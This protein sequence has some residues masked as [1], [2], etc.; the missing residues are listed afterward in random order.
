VKRPTGRLATALLLLGAVVAAPVAS[1]GVASARPEQAPGLLK[2]LTDSTAGGATV[3]PAD[4]SAERISFFGTAP[5]RPA[6]R[7]AGVSAATAPDLAAREFVKGYGGLFGVRDAARELRLMKAPKTGD[8]GVRTVRFQQH[9]G[10]VPVI[11]GDV[12]VQLEAD[13]DVVAAYGETTTAPAALTPAITAEA[14]RSSAVALIARNREVAPATLSAGT[15][16]LAVYDSRILGVPGLDRPTLVWQTEVTASGAD[17]INEKVFV[18]A[19]RG[20][21]A[22]HFDQI[23][24]AEPVRRVCDNA[25]ARKTTDACTTA[26]HSPGAYPLGHDVRNAYDFS[27]RAVAFYRALGRHGLDG[28]GGTISSV[29]RY[30]E[31]IPAGGT[32]ADH[33]CPFRN[34][35]WN[36]KHVVYGDN[37]ANADDVVGH[38]LT[39]GVTDHESGLF[40][41]YQSG[42]INES[43]SDVFGELLD[44][45]YADPG[46]AR[47][48][49]WLIGEDNPGGAIRSMSDP[50]TYRHP[51]RMTSSYWSDYLPWKEWTP[52]SPTTWDAGGVHTNSGVNN[53]A[54]YLISNGGTFNGRTVAPLGRAKTARLYYTAALALTSAASYRDLYNVLL[55]SCNSLVGG[56]DGVTAADCTQVKN[57]LLAVEMST[58][59]RTRGRGP[60]FAPACENRSRPAMKFYDDMENHSSGNWVKT[61]V[62]DANHDGVWRTNP[63]S[64]TTGYAGQ[65]FNPQSDQLWKSTGWDP[66]WATSGTTNMWG[67]NG[68]NIVV[69]DIARTAGLIATG[70]TFLQFNHAYELEYGLVPGSTSPKYFDGGRVEFSVDGARTWAAVPTSWFTHNPYNATIYKEPDARY[71]RWDS[72]LAGARAFG[73]SSKG[74]TTSRISLKALASKPVRFRFRLATDSGGAGYGWFIDDVAVYNC[75]PYS[76]RLSVAVSPSTV[77]HGSATRV[78]GRLTYAGSLGGIAGKAVVIH[79]RR[80]TTPAPR[81]T[82][83]ATVTTDAAGAYRYLAK[84]TVNF[85]YTT[86]FVGAAP[87]LAAPVNEA[88][89][90]YVAPKLTAALNDTTVHRTTTAYLAGVVTPAHGG[91]RVYLQKKVSGSWRNITYLVLPASG[92][93]RLRVRPGVAGTHYYRAAIAAHADHAAGASPTATLRVS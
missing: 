70:G 39:H 32:A 9:F 1:T 7:P 15:P 57:A 3:V 66:T 34:A 54:A 44:L 81:W 63:Y 12:V 69:S 14:A 73:G 2:R 60:T 18:D 25:N 86:R 21:V 53:K 83:L 37:R 22:L 77:V 52:A 24:H 29:V 49:A 56:A 76:T 58:P 64:A 4:G 47:T 5:G 84:P 11:G 16:T 35:Y 43:L 45:Q 23:A 28:A 33:P 20:V 67:D 89:N 61:S 55:Q 92:A 82:R 75:L 41:L 46:E 51:D 78:S 90:V 27:G 6:R 31:A 13:N 71:S 93:Y 19:A 79:G 72:R 80:L 30:C 8:N 65:W 85:E 74:Y 17:E 36:G 48:D 91:R 59:P 38:E 88:P 87:F 68:P 10:G 50:P 62:H 42:A 40:Y 26:V